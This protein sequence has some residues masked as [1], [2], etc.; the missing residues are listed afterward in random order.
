VEYAK[1]MQ[2]GA[3]FDKQKKYA[4]AVQAYTTALHWAP[5]DAKAAAGLR[6]AQYLLHMTDG[7]KLLAARRFADATKEFEE[8]LKLFPNSADAKKDLQKA[9][10]GKP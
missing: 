3:S 7:E 1:A 8:A 6:D 4:D 10:S 5:K 9:K 2:A